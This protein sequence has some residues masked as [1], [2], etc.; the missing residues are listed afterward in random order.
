LQ[1]AGLS[2]KRVQK[3]AAE[4]DPEIRADFICRISQYPATYLLPTDE[5]LKDDRTYARL[6]GRA[7]RRQWV[8]QH[9]PFVRKRRLLMVSTMA[10]DEGIVASRV[11]EGSLTHDLFFEY[12]RDDVLPIMNAFPG[13]RSVILL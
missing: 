5:V 1:Q 10:L 2:T 12:L 3:L 11:V 6:W 9:Y 7:P 4:R 8:Q 13:P